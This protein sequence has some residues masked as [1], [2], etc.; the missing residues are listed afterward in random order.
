[1]VSAVAHLHLESGPDASTKELMVRMGH[2]GIRAALIYQHASLERD[3][4]IG[5]G[6]SELATKELRKSA[7]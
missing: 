5:D 4:A 7:H 1:M 2:S 6:V 3:A